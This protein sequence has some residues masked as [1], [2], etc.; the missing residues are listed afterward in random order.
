MASFNKWLKLKFQILLHGRYSI[1]V[2]DYCQK[3]N[4]VPPYILC[5]NEMPL[6]H[7]ILFIKP[8]SSIKQ[9]STEQQVNFQEIA[10]GE[11]LKSFLRKYK[12]PDCYTI[13]QF[14]KYEIRVYGYRRKTYSK[15]DKNLFYFINGQFAMG[16]I[17]IPVN[18][19]MEK[20]TIL[21]ALGKKYNLELA[22]EESNNFIIKDSSGRLLLFEDNGFQYALRYTKNEF[23][24]LKEAWIKYHKSLFEEF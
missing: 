11:S 10:F 2:N 21:E 6:E 7:M 20:K 13:Q 1:Q 23:Y 16:E 19:L 8:E 5:Y 15:K 9:Y 14:F 24:G 18:P 4:L 3:K 17:L 12:S 22:G